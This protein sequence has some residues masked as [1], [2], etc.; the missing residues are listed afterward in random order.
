MPITIEMQRVLG[1]HGTGSQ[2]QILL[3]QILDFKEDC[4][5]L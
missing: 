2:A 1:G 3:C 4:S 5:A